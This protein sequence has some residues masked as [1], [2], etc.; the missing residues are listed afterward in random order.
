MW[1]RRDGLDRAGGRPASVPRADSCSHTESGANAFAD[2]DSDPDPDPDAN[3]RS[4][5]ESGAN[6]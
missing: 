5:T 6:A 4:D 2:S 1:R 3:T